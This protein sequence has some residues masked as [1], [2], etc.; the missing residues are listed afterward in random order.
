MDIK[1]HESI[2]QGMKKEIDSWRKNFLK[3]RFDHEMNDIL[4]EH[5]SR[6]EAYFM[7]IP[8]ESFKGPWEEWNNCLCAL[9]LH[10]GE[11]E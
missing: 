3:T 11:R 8:S 7:S 10:L 9:I 4:Q 1:E 5:E 2:I 6:L